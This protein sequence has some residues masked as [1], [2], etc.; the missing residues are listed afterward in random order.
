M[1]R[2]NSSQNPKYGSKSRSADGCQCIGGVCAIDPS[3]LNKLRLANKAEKNCAK[4]G[5]ASP[6]Q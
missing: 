2:A 4:S 5:A 1:P 3:F 6:K